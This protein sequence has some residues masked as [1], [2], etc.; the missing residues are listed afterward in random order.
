MGMIRILYP[1]DSGEPYTPEDIRR[2]LHL[3]TTDLVCPRCKYTV[4]LSCHTGDEAV[5]PRCMENDS[6]ET[7]RQV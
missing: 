1:R 5:C 2:G 6:D 4:A 7:T 3:I